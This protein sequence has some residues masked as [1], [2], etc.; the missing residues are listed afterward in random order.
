MTDS[1]KQLTEGM[2]RVRAADR[3]A[4]DE[5]IAAEIRQGDRLVKALAPR[6]RNGPAAGEPK[7]R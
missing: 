4:R 1:A 2:D 7:P 5:A 3:A 6:H